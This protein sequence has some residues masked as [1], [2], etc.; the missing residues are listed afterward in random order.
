MSDDLSCSFIKRR[1][2]QID[3][4]KVDVQRRTDDVVINQ[5]MSILI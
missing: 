2:P 1:V 4:T 5:C 3:R